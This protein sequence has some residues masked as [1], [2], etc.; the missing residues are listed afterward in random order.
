LFRE[1][2]L[3]LQAFSTR[4]RA[5]GVRPRR[6]AQLERDL[7]RLKKERQAS[8]EEM[9]TSQEE[10]KSTNEELQSTNEELQSTN[11]ELTTSKEEMQS[12]NE[13]LLT[14]NAELQNKLDELSR[15]HD[16]MK[17]LLNSTDIATIYL[18]NDLQI[19]RFTPQASGIVRLIASDVGRP[20]SDLVSVLKYD[21]LVRDAQEVLDSL[22]FKERRV[23][24]KDE[25]WFTMRIAP[26]RTA[27][28]LIG[29]VVLTF[30]EITD[31]MRTALALRESEEHLRS[32]LDSMPIMLVATGPD[33]LFAAWNREAARVTGYG[34]EEIIGNPNAPKLLYPDEA[35]RH[36]L[37]GDQARLEGVFRDWETEVTCKDGTVKTIAWYS[38]SR[39]ASVPDW[40]SWELGLDVTERRQGEHSEGTLKGSR[41]C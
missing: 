5:A 13:E 14:V 34:V 8:V 25:R 18:D 12:L 39:L 29:G 32:V 7:G 4:P 17:N 10:L 24:T 31:T 33:H 23:R 26:Y 38:N 21:D 36:R 35:Y 28:N 20:I 27:E 22:A 1:T 41:G 11:E 40:A 2:P 15:A 37:Q 6:V 3:E 9:E 19:K 30:V 16:D